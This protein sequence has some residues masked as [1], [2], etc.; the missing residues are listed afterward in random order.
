METHFLIAVSSLR[1]ALKVCYLPPLTPSC[2]A[3][4][5]KRAL[6]A[7]HDETRRPALSLWDLLPCRN[8]P[9]A[10]WGRRGADPKWA[11]W[12]PTSSDRY[13]VR[14]HVT[15]YRQQ[16]GRLLKCHCAPYRLHYLM[17]FTGWAV[18]VVLSV[19]HRASL[20]Y[21]GF[22][23]AEVPWF[24]CRSHSKNIRK[25][26]SIWHAISLTMPSQVIPAYLTRNL[27]LTTSRSQ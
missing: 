26:I 5:L 19:E 18:L 7:Y 11:R 27:L 1:L 14:E 2:L 25:R 10:S 20:P 4:C 24:C 17:H 13:R 12:L 22:D 21:A 8:R 3:W 6:L 23:Q 9:S 15:V 16:F